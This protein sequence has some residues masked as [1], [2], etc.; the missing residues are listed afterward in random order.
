[1]C[2]VTVIIPT[3]NR[4]DWIGEAVESVLKQTYQDF[5]I[6]IVDDKSSDNTAEV[7]AAFNDARIVFLTQSHAGVS[8]ARNRAS[9][10]PEENTS[11]FW[12]RTICFCQISWRARLRIWKPI[13]M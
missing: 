3:Y 4:A 13:L 11:P 10:G 9:R 2:T 8:A 5:E 12:I 7:I 6:I 1:M